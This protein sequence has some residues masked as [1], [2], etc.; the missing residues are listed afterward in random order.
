MS[1]TGPNQ[2][3]HQI[4]AR[5]T[6]AS[7]KNTGVLTSFMAMPPSVPAGCLSRDAPK[8][9]S[10]NPTLGHT[11][12]PGG[13]CGRSMSRPRVVGAEVPE[14]ALQVAAGVTAAAVGLVLDIDHDLGSRR[15]GPGVVSVGVRDDN[16]RALRFRAADL[17]RLLH[18]VAELV[19]TDGAQHH[20]AVAERQLGVDDHLI[21]IARHN[22]VLLEAERAA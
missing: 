20:N 22:Q 19:L 1:V 14:M 3:H 11:W 16:V 4:A 8:L 10:G 15:L 6:K 2:P 12:W 21:A 9:L 5:A 7:T 18:Q 13:G 17:R